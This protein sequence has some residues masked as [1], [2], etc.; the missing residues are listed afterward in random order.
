M[1]SS[2]QREMDVAGSLIGGAFGATATIT[3]KAV[4]AILKSKDEKARRA[5]LQE[6]K[7]EIIAKHTAELAD[8]IIAGLEDGGL[9]NEP[10]V[11]A[12]VTDYW[13]CM[14]YKFLLLNISEAFA[15]AYFDRQAKF[16]SYRIIMD[17]KELLERT[18]AALNVDIGSIEDV[19]KRLETFVE[20]ED[21]AYARKMDQINPAATAKIAALRA[22]GVEIDTSNHE[23]D[24]RER[25]SYKG[26][27][28]VVFADGRVEATT[29]SGPKRFASFDDMKAYF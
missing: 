11:D 28:Y 7:N 12:L 26:R 3:G 20:D 25:G 2:S 4:S 13:R 1:W 14:T 19:I 27:D 23:A 29:L 21:I 8:A 15:D 16:R 9:A 24:I 6:Y 22:Q 5:A 18:A 17:R 10:Q